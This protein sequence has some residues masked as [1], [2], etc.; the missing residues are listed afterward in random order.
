M[1]PG[2]TERMKLADEFPDAIERMKRCFDRKGIAV[3]D[4]DVV[5]AWSDYSDS[6]CASWLN[7]PDSDE[8][9]LSILVK[10]L[11]SDCARSEISVV[12][13]VPVEGSH[14][15]MWLPLPND[16][17]RAVGWAIGDTVEVTT[18]ADFLVLRRV[19]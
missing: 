1:V 10:H 9:L 14:G 13:I 4:D 17:T 15:D 16:V 6:L 3:S 7:L 11:P 2:L 5:R 19:T 12:T 8:D 18:S